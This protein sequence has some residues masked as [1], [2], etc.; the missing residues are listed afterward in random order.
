MTLSHQKVQDLTFGIL[1]SDELWMILFAVS[2]NFL[3]KINEIS[4]KLSTTETTRNASTVYADKANGSY[5][6]T[7]A[8][9]LK[10]YKA[11]TVLEVFSCRL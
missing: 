9:H 1:T 3:G 11:K 7:P 8:Q 5:K 4:I 10:C 6:K 2:N